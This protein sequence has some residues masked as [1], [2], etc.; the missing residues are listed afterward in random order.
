[1]QFS[2]R[3]HGSRDGLVNCYV[4]ALIPFCLRFLHTNGGNVDV[5]YFCIENI[6]ALLRIRRLMHDSIFH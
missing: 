2:P 1:M 5:L 6:K 3:A 4:F